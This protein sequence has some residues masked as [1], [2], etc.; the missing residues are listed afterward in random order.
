[1]TFLSPPS[2][3]ASTLTDETGAPERTL[4]SSGF[5]ASPSGAVRYSRTSA[6]TPVWV[7]AQAIAI[8]S[9]DPDIEG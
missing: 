3:T 9:P 1:M 2:A 8:R 5:S 4:T 6:Q 7:T